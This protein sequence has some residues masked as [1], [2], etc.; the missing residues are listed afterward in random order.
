QHLRLSTLRRPRRCTLLP[1]TTLFRSAAREEETEGFAERPE[2]VGR[3]FRVG[4]AGQWRDQLSAEQVDRVVSAHGEQMAR[5][6]YLPAES[7]RKSTRLN[8][9]HVKISYAVICLKKK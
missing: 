3:F 7:D 1:Y 2:D 4:R 9:S 5:F 6:G 8:S